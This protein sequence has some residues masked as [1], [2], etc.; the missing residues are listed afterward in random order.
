MLPEAEPHEV[1]HDEGL[2]MTRLRIDIDELAT[3]M[4]HHDAEWV[5]DLRTGDV[6]MT[7]W[8]RDPSLRMEAG[9]ELDCEEDDEA[10]EVEALLESGRFMHIT[11]IPSHE[12]FGWMERFAAGLDDERARRR[13]LGALEQSRP[14]R[15]FKDAL[16][17]FPDIRE[18]WGGYEEE[19]Q[20]RAAMA[21]LETCGIDAE[22]VEIRHPSQPPHQDPSP[23]DGSA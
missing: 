13:L 22:L 18:A 2:S 19:R 21:W 4:A 3:A 8:L 1:P 5:L 9:I 14:F 7:E 10:E 20:R 17:A 12:S 16:L 11:S 15:R 23:R 6:L